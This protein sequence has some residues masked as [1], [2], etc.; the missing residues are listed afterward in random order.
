MPGIRPDLVR[1][2]DDWQE[3]GFTELTK[4]LIKRADLNPRIFYPDKKT[5]NKII[6]IF[7]KK[8]DNLPEPESL[9]VVRRKGM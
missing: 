5:Q 8:T 9:S 6:Y 7:Q 2:Y 1:L 3:H 4:A